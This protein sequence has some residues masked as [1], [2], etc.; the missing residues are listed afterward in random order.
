MK[1][2]QTKASKKFRKKQGQGSSPIVI[3]LSDAHLQIVHALRENKLL[4]KLDVCNVSNAASSKNTIM[5]GLF[6]KQ[7]PSMKSNIST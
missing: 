4:A 1:K 6:E 5:T 2:T 3:A 7:N